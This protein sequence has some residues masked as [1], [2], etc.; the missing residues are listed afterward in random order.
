[1]NCKLVSWL[2]PKSKKK[3]KKKRNS[4]WLRFQV[5]RLH[6]YNVDD[7]M[8]YRRKRA[9]Y[10]SVV[11]QIIGRNMVFFPNLWEDISV[12][13]NVIYQL[14]HML[15]TWMWAWNPSGWKWKILASTDWPSSVLTLAMGLETNSET[16]NLN[17]VSWFYKNEIIHRIW[18]F[19][20]S[21]IKNLVGHNWTS[22]VCSL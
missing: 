17:S 19:N 15:N 14:L 5:W 12:W 11:I 10:Y 20:F 13:K 8:H 6:I 9:L 4:L 7:E 16:K 1:M 21:A 3:K 2:R 22:K 18:V